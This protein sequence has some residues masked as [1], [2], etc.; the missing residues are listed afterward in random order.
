LEIYTSFEEFEKWTPIIG[1]S[2]TPT[3][4][5]LMEK[6][7]VILIKIELNRELNTTSNLKPTM[8]LE[9]S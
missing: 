8:L 4:S 7:E 9:R 3:I 5:T 2:L 1:I 6:D